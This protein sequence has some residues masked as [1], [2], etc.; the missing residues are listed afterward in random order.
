VRES[1]W[2]FSFV[3]SGDHNLESLKFLSCWARAVQN[4]KKLKLEKTEWVY[5]V[6]EFLGEGIISDSFPLA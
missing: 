2:I 5:S 6:G 1:L 3:S 4:S